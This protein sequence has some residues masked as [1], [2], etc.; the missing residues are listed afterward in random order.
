MLP[1]ATLSSDLHTGVQASMLALLRSTQDNF[2]PVVLIYMAEW[3]VRCSTAMQTSMWLGSILTLTCCGCLVMS[4]SC[5]G[6]SQASPPAAAAPLLL[7]VAAVAAAM[8][9]SL[10]VHNIVARKRCKSS[11]NSER[12]RCSLIVKC[13]VLGRCV[14]AVCPGPD[15]CDVSIT[16]HTVHWE[17]GCT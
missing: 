15:S 14:Y 8:S 4:S 1:L 16:A 12:E 7:A 10:Q 9:A 2:Q 13:H 6:A 11:D 5:L 17:A 3:H